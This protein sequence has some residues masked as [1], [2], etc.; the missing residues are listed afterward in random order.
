MYNRVMLIGRLTRDPEFKRT[1]SGVGLTTFSLAVD[2]KYKSASGERETDFIRI[3]AWDK[4]GEL[5]KEYLGKGQLTAVE[6]RLQVRRWETPQG[7]RRSI[8]E[9]RAD[10]VRFLERP[11]GRSSSSSSDEEQHDD[12]YDENYDSGSGGKISAPQKKEDRSSNQPRRKDYGEVSDRTLD[13]EID[14]DD[15]DPFKEDF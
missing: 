11:P 5:C 7:E 2:R 6:G 10:D 3:V 1:S 8:Y 15:D 14:L 4:L 9:V 13:E 12:S